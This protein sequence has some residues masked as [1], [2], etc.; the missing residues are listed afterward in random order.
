M[1]MTLHDKNE[2][3]RAPGAAPALRRA[4]QILDLIASTERQLTAADITRALDLPKSTAHGL[5]KALVELALLAHSPDGTLRIGAHALR[6]TSSFLSRLDIVSIFQTHLE[7]NRTFDRFTATLT[8][9]DGAEVVYVGCR[10]SDQP[11]GQMFRIGMRLP[12]PFTATGKMLLSDLSPQDLAALFDQGFPA[13]LTSRSITDLAQL[14]GELIE[15]QRRGY[16]IDDGET[17]E[18]MLCLGAAVRDHT[19]KAIAGM[20]ITLMR[21]EADDSSLKVYGEAIRNSAASLSRR[22][23]GGY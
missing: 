20:A 7:E 10:H 12:A 15:T 13:P 19:G 11:L 23:G 4:V 6:W 17:R 1:D 22:L 14:K 2:I 3:E 5:I 21:A 18:G 16:S 9:R 8:V